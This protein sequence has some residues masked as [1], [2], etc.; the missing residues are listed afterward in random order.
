VKIKF[1]TAVVLAYLLIPVPV[2]RLVFGVIMRRPRSTA[3]EAL[4]GLRAGEASAFGQAA[5][6]WF[7][8]PLA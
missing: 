3:H 1:L 4:A 5:D 6:T 2:R 7:S 8:G